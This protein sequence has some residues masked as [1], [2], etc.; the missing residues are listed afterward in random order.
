MNFKLLIIGLL[1]AFAGVLGALT[2]VPGAIDNL[3][4]KRETVSVGRA[5]VGGP[6]ELTSHNGRRVTNKDFGGQLMLVYFGFTYCPDI[7]PAGLQVISAALDKM[8]DRATGVAPLFISVDPERDTPEQ[9]KRYMDSFHKSIL[10]LTGSA[11]DVDKAA[12]AY[13]V[14][15]RKAKDPTLS[16]YTIDHTSFIYLMDTKGEY[17]THFPH[18]VAPDELAK[19]LLSELR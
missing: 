1:A 15:Y 6:F 18:A 16:E 11:E 17:I 5:L 4:P 12:K 3:L 7:C 19:R 13:R 2:F 9:L 14:Y 8:G 10:G